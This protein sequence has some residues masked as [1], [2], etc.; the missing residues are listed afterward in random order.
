MSCPIGN[1]TAGIL[2]LNGWA[3]HG[4]IAAI[5]AAVS[6]PGFNHGFTV[7]TFIE[8]LAGVGGHVFFFLMPAL[9][10]GDRGLQYGFHFIDD[11][12]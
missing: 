9:G 11:F 1:S 2:L 3:F 4:S 5:H 12:D 8:K 7:F 6:L 10:A